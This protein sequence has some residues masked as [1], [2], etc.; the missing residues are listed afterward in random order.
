MMLYRYVQPGSSLQPGSSQ[1]GDS[2]LSDQAPIPY[3]PYGTK[4][5]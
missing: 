5:N 3:E 1:Q 4:H 2:V